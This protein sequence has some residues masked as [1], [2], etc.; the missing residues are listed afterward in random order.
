MSQYRCYNNGKKF[1]FEGE[2]VKV[3]A[4][5]APA[6]MQK[7]AR[8]KIG[9]EPCTESTKSKTSTRNKRKRNAS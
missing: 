2:G 6:L 8:L 3:M 4:E 7:I 5:T 9:V 1:V